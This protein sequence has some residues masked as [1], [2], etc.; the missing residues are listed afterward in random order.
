[1]KRYLYILILLVFFLPA[2]GPWPGSG[3][4]QLMAKEELLLECSTKIEGYI[5]RLDPANAL[6][7]IDGEK[8]QLAREVLVSLNGG[9]STLLALKPPAPGFYNWGEFYLDVWNRV[10]QIDAYYQVVEG[11]LLEISQ[12]D[13]SLL[14]LEY[15]QDNTS[16]KEE[17]QR[18]FLPE[19][20][21]DF[22]DLKENMHLI[23]IVA[24]DRILAIFY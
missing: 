14:L 5:T 10:L 24:R 18:Y 1:M 20:K 16:S 13:N 3:A 11:L 21:E 8:Y 12:E 15:R 19:S 6:I 17:Y 4:G 23:L 9:P 2:C 7:F 22:V